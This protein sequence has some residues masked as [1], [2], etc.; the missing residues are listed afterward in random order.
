MYI[1]S[2]SIKFNFT[3][4]G[5][6]KRAETRVVTFSCKRYFNAL[7]QLS[8]ITKSERLF[9]DYL[10]EKMDSRTNLVDISIEIKKNFIEEIKTWTGG[11]TKVAQASLGS[12]IKSLESARLITRYNDRR[13]LYMVNPKYAF[14]G[15][16]LTRKEL[17][18][19]EIIKCISKNLPFAHLID[20]TEEEFFKKA[21]IIVRS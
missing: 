9:Y 21:T 5:V 10:C 14:K 1:T 6:E 7:H 4:E 15:G 13:A 18:R 16:E 2:P 19:D 17:I 20:T 12:F 3:Q 8:R 11:K